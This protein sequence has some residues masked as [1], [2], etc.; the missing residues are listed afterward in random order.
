MNEIMASQGGALA[1]PDVGD[2][3]LPEKYKNGAVVALVFKG[4]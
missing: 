2:V 3:E 4:E 1:F